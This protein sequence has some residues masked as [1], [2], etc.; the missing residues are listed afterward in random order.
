MSENAP[1]FSVIV[2]VYNRLATLPRC[3]ASVRAQ[4]FTDWELIAIDDGSTDGSGTLLAGEADARVRVLTHVANRGVCPARNTGI[5]AAR[6]AWLVFLDSDDELAGPESLARMAELAHA[7]PFDVAALWFRCRN[8]D[9]TLSPPF[10]P[11]SRDL[12]YR[13]YL[14]FIEL[15]HGVSRDM[16]R[17]VRATSF[18]RIRYPDNRMLEDK[19]HLDFA[20]LHR[21]RLHDDVLRLYHQDAPDQLVVRL[22][23][24]DPV[25]DRAFI[26]DRARGLAALMLQ[27]G[28]ALARHAPRAFRGLSKRTARQLARA[29]LSSARRPA[30]LASL[31]ALAGCGTVDVSRMAQAPAVPVTTIVVPDT[32]YRVRP[33]DVL[34]IRL[35]LSPE[36]DEEVT[37]RPDGG[38]SAT[39]APELHAAGHT[40]PELEAVLDQAYKRQLVEPQIAVVVKSS[41]P[42]RVFVAGAVGTPGEIKT[43]QN[44]L[45]LTEAIASAGGVK[46]AAD[47]RRVFILRHDGSG[48]AH[49]LATRYKD[50]IDGADPAADVELASGDVVMVPRS[51]IAMGYSYWNQYIQQFVPVSWGFS[52]VLQQAARGTTVTQPAATVQ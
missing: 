7:A 8:D 6:G 14:R 23:R 20:H 11:P 4:S 19:F 3:I 44:T 21:S 26:I 49:F 24:L 35:P 48:S 12:D 15:T 37:V 43:D 51:S 2:P 27:H 22:G 10:L 30:F 41:A 32:P 31:V 50:V 47:E 16:I 39:L 38:I 42:I 40:I 28:P 45:T 29:A 46:L 25:R 5:A 13:G 36:L 9:G 1:F 52:Y 34:S 18:A 17:C 33:G